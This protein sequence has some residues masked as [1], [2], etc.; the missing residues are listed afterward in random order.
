VKCRHQR[1]FTL[2]ELLV[3]IGIISILIATLLPALTKARELSKQVKCAANMR[4]LGAAIHMYLG[5]NRQTFPYSYYQDDREPNPG[6]ISWDMA[7]YRYLGGKTAVPTSPGVYACPSDDR[8]RGSSLMPRS[9][10]LTHRYYNYS[11][12]SGGFKGWGVGVYYRIRAD[13][14]RYDAGSANVGD[15]DS[16]P[17]RITFFNDTSKTLLLVER[18]AG[19]NV[20][21]G[22]Y[23]TT[24]K[25]PYEQW[26]DAPLRK[27][28][29][30]G[31]RKW[32]Y[33][34]M[35]GHVD[36]FEPR[37]TIH[38]LAASTLAIPNAGNP[39]GFWSKPE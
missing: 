21:G 6:L 19:G 16:R 13:G 23:F 18:P 11:S 32:N 29:H 26:R 12:F 17:R 5:E 36:A 1:A 10:A 15:I 8:P 25:D 35:D 22:V 27:P 24:A 7:I 38:P 20:I 39:H 37:E 34:F 4:Q 3:V 2:V 33:L 9:Y 31:R 28:T 14:T 30:A